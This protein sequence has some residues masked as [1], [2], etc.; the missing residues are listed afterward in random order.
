MDGN[1]ITQNSWSGQ[2]FPVTSGYFQL[3]WR[4]NRDNG[5]YTCGQDDGYPVL[6]SA[7]IYSDQ[8]VLDMNS[9]H[10]CYTGDKESY[11]E[12]GKEMDRW[13]VSSRGP[14]P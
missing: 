10:G 7:Q 1:I 2:R 12:Y 13:K 6:S 3:S 8:S 11:G 14:E 4:L 9:Q 5:P